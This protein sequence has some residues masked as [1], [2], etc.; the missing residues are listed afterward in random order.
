MHLETDED[1]KLLYILDSLRP[2]V[3][4]KVVNETL[5]SQ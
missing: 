2:N 5:L 1:L 4:K 3:E